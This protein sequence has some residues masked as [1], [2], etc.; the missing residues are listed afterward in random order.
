MNILCISFWAP[1]IVRPQSIL[2]GKMLPEWIRQGVNPILVTYDICGKWDL[3]IP[4][5]YVSTITLKSW[6]K[7]PIIRQII[8]LVYYTQ[9]VITGWQAIKKHNVDAIFS[10]ANPQDS[11]IMGALLKWITGVPFIAHFSDP[12]YD[13]PYKDFVGIGAWKIKLLESLIIH[14]ADRIVF[15]NDVARNLVMK[16]Y[17]PKLQERAITIPHCYE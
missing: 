13:N 8:A 9:L 7:M 2:L 11:N 3:D 4:T 16:K 1:P 5:Y 17:N 10:F 12:W 14:A 15:T 6:Q